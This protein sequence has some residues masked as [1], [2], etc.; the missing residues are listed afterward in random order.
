MQ[1]FISV[2]LD[3]PESEVML[4][5]IMQHIKPSTGSLAEYIKLLLDVRIEKG[6]TAKT[7]YD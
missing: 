6:V 5:F 2:S 1:V 3:C 4:F 7:G